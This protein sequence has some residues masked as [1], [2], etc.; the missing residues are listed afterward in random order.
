MP[1]RSINSFL[2]GAAMNRELSLK[3]LHE[4]EDGRL[5]A[6]FNLAL[7]NIVAD[8]KN[9]CG[10]DV[11]RKL[12]VNIE[13]TPVMLGNQLEQVNVLASVAHN[14]PKLGSSAPTALK[15]RNNGD[16][17]FSID[18]DHP[19]Q[20]TFNDIRAGDGDKPKPE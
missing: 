19:D 7:S 2:K 16:L 10:M 11:K 18:A 13:F 17:I 4:L 20:T 1:R 14:I 9:R 3:T 6:A 12:I 8:L 5:D 15:V